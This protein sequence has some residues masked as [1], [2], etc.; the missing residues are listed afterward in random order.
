V[1]LRFSIAEVVVLRSAMH[2]YRKE[3]NRRA[4]GLKEK[5]GESAI[6][7]GIVDQLLIMDHID[8]KLNKGKGEMK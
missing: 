4:R 8:F 5:W 7:D 3:C 1:D 6:V 2:L